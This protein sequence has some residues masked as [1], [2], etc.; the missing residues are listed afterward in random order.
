ML[1]WNKGTWGRF[2]AHNTLR[3]VTTGIIAG[4][5]VA[6]EMGWRVVEAVAEGDK[7]LTFDGGLQTVISVRRDLISADP[8]VTPM[9]HWPL[10]VPAGA[11]G[12]REAMRLLPAQ[13][14]LVESDTAEDVLGDPFALIPAASLDGF[15]GI[16]RPLP[17]GEIEI[18]HLEFAQD[19]IVFANLGALFLCKRSTSILSDMLHENTESP[20]QTLSTEE[21]DVLVGFLEVEDEGRRRAPA[22]AGAR[23]MV[24]AA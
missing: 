19:E 5:K 20:Y 16:L 23:M 9:A 1:A 3:D 13:S 15:R 4:T 22:R 10:D 6:T 17:G 12:N 7:V 21:A 14:I 11:L 8:N 2:T 24:V 18:V